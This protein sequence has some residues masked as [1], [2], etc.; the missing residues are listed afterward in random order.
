MTMRYSVVVRETEFGYDVHCPALPGCHSQGDSLE[1]A[2]ENIKDAI[3]TYLHMIA[4]ETKD[5]VVYQVEI[6][7]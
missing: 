3:E 2:V 4:E 6:S 5:S 7:A 1:E